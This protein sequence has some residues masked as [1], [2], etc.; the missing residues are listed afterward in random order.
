MRERQLLFGG[1]AIARLQIALDLLIEQ[2]RQAIRQASGDQPHRRFTAGAATSGHQARCRFGRETALMGLGA[3]G[4]VA[5]NF[6]W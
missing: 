5:M 1:Q 3:R 6:A 2:H 4:D